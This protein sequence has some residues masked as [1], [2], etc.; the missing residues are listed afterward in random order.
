M[1]HDRLIDRPPVFVGTR[2][3]NAIR[4]ALADDSVSISPDN[5]FVVHCTEMRIG[6]RLASRSPVQ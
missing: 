2:P 4:G 1:M 5:N 6:M 3:V